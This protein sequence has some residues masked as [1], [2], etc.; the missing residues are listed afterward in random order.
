VFLAATTVCVI[1][2]QR[3]GLGAILGFIVAGVLTGRYT[4]GP[5]PVHAVEELSSIAELDRHVVIVG[6]DEVGDLIDLMLE[7]TNIPH[8]AV[9]RDI[10]VVQRAKHGGRDL[11][12]GD[13]YSPTTH[14]PF[15]LGKA[16]VVFVTSQDSDAAKA[17]A[18]TLYRI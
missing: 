5:V 4:P 10:N 2:F 13:I 8:I 3:L 15:G 16:A 7:R 1:L 12:F 18:L 17:Q 6:Y 14:E 9:E 11:S